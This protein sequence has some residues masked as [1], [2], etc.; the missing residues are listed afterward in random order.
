MS[1]LYKS[2]FVINTI[3]D[4]TILH[5]GNCGI[6]FGV[7]VGFYKQRR[8][9]GVT[10]Y[11]PNGHPRVF[12]GETEEAKLQRQL[13]SARAHRDRLQAENYHLENQRRAQKGATTRL[14]NR[15]AAGVC[16]CCTRTFQNLERHMT[17]QHP[18]WSDKESHP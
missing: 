6:S 1:T 4:I 9:D 14:K 10:W 8:H 17:S 12:R 5:C 3:L 16:P 7:P 13:E 15:I 2:D 11:C 18:G